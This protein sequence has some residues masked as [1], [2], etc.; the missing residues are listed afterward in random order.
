MSALVDA[1]S[2]LRDADKALLGAAEALEDVRTLS[3]EEADQVSAVLRDCVI[4]PANDLKAM[5]AGRRTA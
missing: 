1:L 2:Y 3:A 4:E 5:I